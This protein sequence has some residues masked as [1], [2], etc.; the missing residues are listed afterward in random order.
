MAEVMHAKPAFY[1]DIA[2]EVL[3]Q[4]MII[5]CWLACFYTEFEAKAQKGAGTRGEF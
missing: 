4:I 3:K 5:V 2:L 1:S